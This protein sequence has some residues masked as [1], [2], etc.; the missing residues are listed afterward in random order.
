MN[1]QTELTKEG[2]ILLLINLRV[3]SHFL[4]DLIESKMKYIFVDEP[5]ED[6]LYWQN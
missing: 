5:W 3:V 1:Y 4:N 2:W 6:Y